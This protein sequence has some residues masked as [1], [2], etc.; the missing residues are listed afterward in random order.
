[1]ISVACGAKTWI[2]YHVARRR[3]PKACVLQQGYLLWGD[4]QHKQYF[5]F[6]GHVARLPPERLVVKYVC[7]AEWR[8]MQQFLPRRGEGTLVGVGKEATIYASGRFRLRTCAR[9]CPDEPS[10]FIL[11]QSRDRWRSIMQWLFNKS[12]LA[13]YLLYPDK[14]T[15]T[16]GEAAFAHF[17]GV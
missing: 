11:G 8:T 5:S 16:R 13:D 7:L 1:M 3:A 4:Q 17:G 2:E 9:E 14:L 15:S 10:W 6:A 12:G